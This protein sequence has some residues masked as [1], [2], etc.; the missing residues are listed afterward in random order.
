MA[1]ENS[2]NKVEY[3]CNCASTNNPKHTDND[4]ESV[5]LN[6]ALDNTVSC[7]YDVKEGKAKDDFC[8][9]REL[10]DSFYEILK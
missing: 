3:P 5:L 9:F 8:D 7:P 1:I 4:A 10:V 6:Y 2:G